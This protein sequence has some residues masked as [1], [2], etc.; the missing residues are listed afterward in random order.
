MRITALVFASI[1]AATLNASPVHGGRLYRFTSTIEVLGPLPVP[2]EMPFATGQSIV[3]AFRY[4]PELGTMPVP[5]AGGHA[6]F[7]GAFTELRL[8][9]NLGGGVYRLAAPDVV[10]PG[11][12]PFADTPLTGIGLWDDVLG[13]TLD[14]FR[15]EHNNPQFLGQP[16]GPVA[17]AAMLGAFFPSNFYAGWHNESPVGGPA[18]DLVAG[19]TLP[20]GLNE[21]FVRSDLA[22][23]VLQFTERAAVGQTQIGRGFQIQGRLT[24]LEVIPEPTGLALACVA[25]AAIAAMRRRN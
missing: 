6:S 2:A 17:P 18:P 4:S 22:E 14:M 24:S 1:V 8:E 20:A 16:I 3:G 11:P 10:P 7:A 13:G 23:W 19:F 25:A 21:L 5:P 15:L 9:I 12:P